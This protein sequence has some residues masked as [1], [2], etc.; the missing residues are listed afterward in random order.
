LYS[1]DTF[2]VTKAGIYF[3]RRTPE[4][5][6]SINFMSFST[7]GVRELARIH[8]PLGSGLTVCSDGRSLLFEQADQIGSDLMLVENFK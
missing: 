7:Q 6:A 2:A 8:A 1:L 3:A 4:N 5:D